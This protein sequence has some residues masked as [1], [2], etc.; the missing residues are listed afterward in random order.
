MCVQ[1]WLTMHEALE[2]AALEESINIEG[3]GLVEGGHD[4]DAAD[5]RVRIAAPSVF[6]RLL[7]L[8]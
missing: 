1:G 4:I 7:T 2:A 8:K 3:W 6:A 5:M